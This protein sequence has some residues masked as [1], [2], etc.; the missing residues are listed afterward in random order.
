[1]L[2]LPSSPRGR[3]VVVSNFPAI[4]GGRSGTLSEET[5]I[6]DV[7]GMPATRIIGANKPDQEEWQ[8]QK[9]ER[10]RRV[11]RRKTSLQAGPGVTCRSSRYGGWSGS[12]AAGGILRWRPKKG[13]SF[14]HIVVSSL[15]RFLPTTTLQPASLASSPISPMGGGGGGAGLVG[16][17][18]SIHG[19]KAGFQFV[20]RVQQI[21]VLA[22]VEILQQL[23]LPG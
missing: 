20:Q 12:V 5:G 15:V 9:M 13:T 8:C 1:M 21:P 2:A 18:C 17:C 11:G 14:T 4:L 16:G 3:I 19:I 6:S 22:G 7:T 10:I 23:P